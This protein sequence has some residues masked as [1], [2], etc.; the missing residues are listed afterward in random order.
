MI[1]NS[2][3]FGNSESKGLSVL[4]AV[5][6]SALNVGLTAVAGGAIGGVAG[7]IASLTPYTP[8]KEAI[9]MQYGDMFL[10][11]TM[12]E[13]L[14]DYIARKG[15]DIVDSVKLGAKLFRKDIELGIQAK[16]AEQLYELVK[17]LPEA[18]LRGEK[19]QG[20][21]KEFFEGTAEMMPVDK[22]SRE[23][24]M[25]GIKAR[26]QKMLRGSDSINKKFQGLQ[27]TFTDAV[28]KDFKIQD[29][30]ERSARDLRKNAIIGAGI[31]VG[32]VGA[33]VLNIL[34][35]YGVIGKRQNSAPANNLAGAQNNIS[36]PLKTTQG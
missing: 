26:F 28:S 32:V 24:L 19:V 36:Q 21:L 35:T 3:S 18:E 2:I 10:K 12:K 30:V 17:T 8:S 23:Q 33:L 31:A 20:V 9:N 29:M 7:K 14:P 34:K 6:D 5:K 4:G 16:N 22:A 27:E 25:D 11:A 15:D 13:E 1:N